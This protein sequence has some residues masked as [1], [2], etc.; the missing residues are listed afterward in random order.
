MV[1]GARIYHL[2]LRP[3]W[4]AAR[5]DG[6]YRRS[7][8][9][10]SLEEVGFIHCSMAHQVQTIADLVYGGR[11]DVVLLEVD[12]DRLDAE[13]R[14]EPAHGDEYPHI[15]GPLPVAAVVRTHDVADWLRTRATPRG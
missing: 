10:A 15:Y 2:A 5:A 7:T 1:E 9:G 6:A 4:E 12:P 13:V 3:E 11:D 8:L 14:V